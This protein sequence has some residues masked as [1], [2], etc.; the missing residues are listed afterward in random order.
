MNDSQ[1]KQLLLSAEQAAEQAVDQTVT[2]HSQSDSLTL[3]KN[4]RKIATRRTHTKNTALLCLP[5]IA[6]ISLTLYTPQSPTQIP[7]QNIANAKPQSLPT[8]NKTKIAA[9]KTVIT[10]YQK[11]I[12]QA[13]NIIDQLTKL[14]TQSLAKKS[15]ALNPLLHLN[16]QINAA[17]DHML[18]RANRLAQLNTPQKNQE[19]KSLLKNII[20]YFPN[21]NSAIIAQQKLT[22]IP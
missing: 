22:R 17:A 9:L 19:T 14:E 1:L 3:A 20:D 2:T 8:Q 21:S 16:E 4:A 18:Q 11:E 15:P 7:S 6:A 12:D 5:L 13:Q 10:Q